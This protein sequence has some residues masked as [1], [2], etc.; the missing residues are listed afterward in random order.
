[1]QEKKEFFCKVNVEWKRE[2]MGILKSE[3]FHDIDIATPPKF[4]GHPGLWTPEHLYVASLT[5]CFM[6]TFL[7]IA[8]ISNLNFLSFQLSGEGKLE[9]IEPFKKIISEIKLKPVITVGSEA[10]KK[11]AEK[12]VKKAHENCIIANSMKTTVEVEPLI[13]V[14]EASI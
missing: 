2:K 9:E 3:G 10:L 13:I 6:S 7:S 8:E 4:G 1:M 11:R 5:S 14:K 12:L